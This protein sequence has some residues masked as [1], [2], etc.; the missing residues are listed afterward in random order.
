MV[1]VSP[2]VSHRNQQTFTGRWL[3]TGHSSEPWLD[4]RDPGGT[5]VRRIRI[6]ALERPVTDRAWQALVDARMA[7]AET[8][9]AR[10]IV[11]DLAETPRP[12]ILPAFGRFLPDGPERVWIALP[13]APDAGEGSPPRWAIVHLEDGTVGT[14]TLPP[15]FTLRRITDDV[16]LGVE[17]DALDVE[18]VA[19]Y[20]RIR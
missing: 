10:Q 12:E 3:V 9:G 5:L 7:E 17:R 6:P 8:A 1:M 2:L 18:S 19:E 11:L 20:R 15:G 4:V 14:V 16:L 13:D